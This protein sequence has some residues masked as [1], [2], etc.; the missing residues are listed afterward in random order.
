M[1]K[2]IRAI[3]AGCAL[4]LASQ[5]MGTLDSGDSDHVINPESCHGH[6]HTLVTY[7]QETA[8]LE[9]RQIIVEWQHD[10][11]VTLRCADFTQHMWCQ[12]EEL[13][14]EYG[15]AVPQAPEE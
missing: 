6:L 4:G 5:G 13:H 9:G 3:I 11:S 14:I 15:D 1:K 10:G 7:L 12:D 2:G 8:L